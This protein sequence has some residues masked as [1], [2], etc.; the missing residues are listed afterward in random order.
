MKKH[1]S[2]VVTFRSIS[3]VEARQ[4]IVL[5]FIRYLCCFQGI[6]TSCSNT[7]R[8]PLRSLVSFETR[9]LCHLTVEQHMISRL[10]SCSRNHCDS[11]TL[12]GCSKPDL[13][14]LY[15]TLQTT[16][17]VANALDSPCDSVASSSEAIDFPYMVI[18][19]VGVV[20]GWLIW[21]VRQVTKE[22]E[23]DT[24]IR[25]N[26]KF[27]LGQNNVAC[28]QWVGSAGTTFD[29]IGVSCRAQV[30]SFFRRDV[31]ARARVLRHTLV[32]VGFDVPSTLA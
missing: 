20:F 19:S 26:Y 1:P 11:S 4:L 31:F 30:L 5:R 32:W 18:S 10:T 17:V 13:L 3:V 7:L 16:T 29:S 24:R 8:T 6:G 14:N 25:R 2:W 27:V 15:Y 9:F 28:W 21:W 23:H 22:V 12:S